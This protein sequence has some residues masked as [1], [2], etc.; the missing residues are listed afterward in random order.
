AVS[1]CL[2]MNEGSRVAKSN[3][4]E[5]NITKGVLVDLSIVLSL[6][7]NTSPKRAFHA[8]QDDDTSLVGDLVSSETDGACLMRRLVREINLLLL[9]VI[10]KKWTMSTSLF[11]EELTR[12]PVWVKLHDVLL[13][14]F[15]RDRISRIA[16]QIGMPIML[17]SFTSSLCI[18]SCGWSS[19]GHCLIEVKADEP[20]KPKVRFEP[21][22]HGISPKNRAPNV[23]ISAKDGHN[24][25]H[26]SSKE[27][28]AKAVDIPSSSYTSGTAKKV[29][30]QVPTSSSNNPISNPYDLLSQEFDPENCSRS[31]GDPNV[32]DD[33]ESE[34]EVEFVFDET[35]NLLKSTKMRVNTYMAPDVSKT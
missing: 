7:E 34:E 16:T 33:M 17:Y 3:V 8:L 6:G 19:F 29:G 18:D 11:K 28:P 27:Q 22:A 9:T 21:K 13:P 23:S 10:L 20:I 31:K 35:V 12:I 32:L 1:S 2:R 24:I 4:N 25:V 26:T 14:I 15:S 5:S 30:R